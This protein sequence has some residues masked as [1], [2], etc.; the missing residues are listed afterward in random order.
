MKLT[1]ATWDHDRCMPLHDG[2]VNVPGVEFESH[3]LPTGK[4]FPIAV[5]QARFDV[6]ELSIS[7]YIL[8]VSRGD[9][10]YTAIPAFVSRAFRHSGFYACAGAG[11]TGLGDLAGKR[12]GVPEY[13]MTA[14]L[15]MRGLL[16]DEYG[17]DPALVHWRTGALDAGVRHER[18]ALDLP[19]GMIVEPVKD[20]E[21]LQDLLLS[22]EIDGLL[23]PNPP[24]AFLDNDPRIERIIPDFGAAERAY[25][26]RT[27]F[28][29][30][31][32]LVAVRKSLID[33]DPDLAVKLLDAFTEARDIALDRLRAIWLGS[34]NRLSLPWLGE[35]MEA[36]CAAM[37][38]DYWRYGFQANRA[39]IETACRYSSEQFLAARRVTPQELFPE[40][41][42]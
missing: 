29:P 24:K 8:Q 18:L 25:H 13:Q 37:G 31:M 16:A 22:G 41:V 32:H 27:G 9:S 1:L 6:T 14:A 2:R 21:T 39:E 33:A 15:W 3:I 42:R 23:A 38:A 34:A 36:T 5:Q 30:I 28:F 35:A 10:V 20:G 12:L 19:E 11:I 26:A 4:L 40:A 17:V 7:S